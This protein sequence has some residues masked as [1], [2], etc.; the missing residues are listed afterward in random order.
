MAEKKIETTKAEERVALEHIR[1]ILAELEPNGY[2]N[3]AFEGCCDIAES[4]INY[5]VIN[6]YKRSFEKL[7]EE[8]EESY[9]ARGNSE[10]QLNAVNKALDRRKDMLDAMLEENEHLKSENKKLKIKNEFL[11]AQLHAANAF[12][13]AN[14]KEEYI[15]KKEFEHGNIQEVINNIPDMNLA[16]KEDIEKDALRMQSCLYFLIGYLR[17]EAENY[18]ERVY[19]VGDIVK[20]LNTVVYGRE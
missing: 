16:K 6:S 7:K 13:N 2:V 3:T 12:F 4:N 20:L 14:Q 15:M 10:V 18:P 17:G 19:A 9:A 11:Q 5:D 8:L 1:N